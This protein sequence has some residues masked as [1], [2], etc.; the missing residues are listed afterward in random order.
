MAVD[1]STLSILTFNYRL[2]IWLALYSLVRH[3]VDVQPSS[4]MFRLTLK[5]PG[6][7]P[8]GLHNDYISNFMDSF[9]RYYD[10]NGIEFLYKWVKEFSYK[11]RAGNFHY[12]LWM[13]TDGS[14]VQNP[15]SFRRKAIEVWGRKIG[16]PADGLVNIDRLDVPGSYTPHGIMV[17]KNAQNYD[18]LMWNVWDRLQYLAKAYS[19][20]YYPY[21]GDAFGGTQV[22]L[23]SLDEALEKLIEIMPGR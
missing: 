21:K 1:T 7:V 12:H 11:S 23:R 18:Y 20:E 8:Y 10:R 6:D 2:D 22:P 16:I 5:V 17:R 13:I 9:C 4:L 14:K 15:F 19:K 3:A